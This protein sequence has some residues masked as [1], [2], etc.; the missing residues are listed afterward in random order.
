MTD[1][2]GRDTA[3]SEIEV[4]YEISNRP[5]V[6][7]EFLIG[8]GSGVV[9]AIGGAVHQA[10][11]VDNQ[12]QTDR[13]V[14]EISGGADRSTDSVIYKLPSVD[15]FGNG[16]IISVE[17]EQMRGSGSLFVDLSDSEPNHD[18]QLAIRE[19]LETASDYTGVDHHDVDLYLSFDSADDDVVRLS[20]KSWE[21]GLI[22]TFAA[23]LTDTEVAEDTL[24]TGVVGDD[25]AMIPVGSVK[26]KAQVAR[27]HG[28]DRLIVPAFQAVEVPGISV[29]SA[30]AIDSVIETVTGLKKNTTVSQS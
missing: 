10:E 28:A 11:D 4:G 18:M 12:V 30:T 27:R 26:E 9:G 22:V 19:A 17:I 7:R 23:V 25:G 21:A 5:L 13:Q 3:D 15:Y 24:T 8:L 20:G 6:R 2:R 16:Q 14:A 29:E 1:D